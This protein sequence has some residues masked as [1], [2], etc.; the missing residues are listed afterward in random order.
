LIAFIAIA[1][2]SEGRQVYVIQPGDTPSELSAKFAPS[3]AEVRAA[4]PGVDFNT[5]TVG[6]QVRNPYPEPTE[7]KDLEGEVSRLKGELA[8]VTGERDAARRA[9]A[10][11]VELNTKLDAKVAELKPLADQAEAY[12][13]RFWNWVS[14][15]SALLGVAAILNILAWRVRRDLDRRVLD[16]QQEVARTRAEGVM[17]AAAPRSDAASRPARANGADTTAHHSH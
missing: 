13:D 1:S 12:R 4:N 5:L 3:L 6:K 15:L 17:A 16:L 10:A 14:G 8:R 7:L 2:S 11:S 9:E